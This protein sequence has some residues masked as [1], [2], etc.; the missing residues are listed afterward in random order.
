MS[1]KI[2][3]NDRCHCGSGIKYKKCCLAQDRIAKNASHMSP[4]ELDR[5]AAGQAALQ[6]K[7]ER[8][9]E[10]SQRDE[11]NAFN[12]YLATHP[13]AEPGDTIK[14]WAEKHGIYLCKPL[15]PE[16]MEVWAKAGEERKLR[17]PV[18]NSHWGRSVSPVA[19]I[20][21]VLSFYGECE[22]SLKG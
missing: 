10:Q 17:E 12:R 13:D 22:K 16:Q 11:V 3:R 14:A 2:G 9:I 21:A 1:Y 18:P 6:V 20:A 19:A 15:T 4:A 5:F 8:E 7:T